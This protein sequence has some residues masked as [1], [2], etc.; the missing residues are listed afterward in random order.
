MGTF[1]K[2]QAVLTALAPAGIP[3]TAAMIKVSK[4][5]TLTGDEAKIVK[6]FAIFTS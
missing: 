5:K 2:A 1:Y 6:N 4:T 3:K